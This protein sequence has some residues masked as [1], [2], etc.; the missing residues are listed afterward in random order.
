[1]I[2][3][4][5]KL[6]G[7][8]RALAV[9]GIHYQF[10][11]K[12]SYYLELSYSTAGRQVNNLIPFSQFLHKLYSVVCIHKSRPAVNP[13]TQVIVRKKKFPPNIPL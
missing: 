2:L 8:S 11:N 4:S 6:L 7:L 3:F 13:A 5:C 9:L 12:K 10:I 1:M